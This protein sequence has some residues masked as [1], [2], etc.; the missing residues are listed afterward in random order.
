MS[1]DGSS[2]RE[3]QRVLK[4]TRVVVSE[5]DD[6]VD[7]GDKETRSICTQKFGTSTGDHVAHGLGL[8]VPSTAMTQGSKLHFFRSLCLPQS[9]KSFAT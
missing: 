4:N 5:C 6:V 9:L 8:G 2:V 7:V 3:E 1:F